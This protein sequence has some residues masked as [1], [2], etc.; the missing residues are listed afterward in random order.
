MHTKTTLAVRLVTRV[1][2]VTRADSPKT[3]LDRKTFFG[4]LLLLLFLVLVYSN[5]LTLD[6]RSPLYTCVLLMVTGFVQK[7][8]NEI[9]GLL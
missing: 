8:E 1:T 3:L 2:R 9:Q 4:L 5:G 6:L 7:Q